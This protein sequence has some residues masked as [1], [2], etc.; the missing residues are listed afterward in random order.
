MDATI[1]QSALR[2]AGSSSRYAS[3]MDR[4]TFVRKQAKRS[5]F[6]VEEYEQ[7][8]SVMPCECGKRKC[9]GWSVRYRFGAERRRVAQ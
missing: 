7:F 5:G 4:D 1:N 9:K 8:F 2:R 6:S 3:R